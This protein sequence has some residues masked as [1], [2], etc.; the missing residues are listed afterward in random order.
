VACAARHVGSPLALADGSVHQRQSAYEMAIC[1]DL[2]KQ[3]MGKTEEKSLTH[4]NPK[5]KIV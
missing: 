1:G 3:K 2:D 5:S 4:F